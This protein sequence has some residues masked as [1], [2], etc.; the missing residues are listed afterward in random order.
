[1]NPEVVL[2]TAY[3]A[4]LTSGAFALEWLS[5]H[6]HRR[7][8][9]YRTAGFTYDPAHDH[10]RCP[11]GGHLW[12]YE[13]DRQLR[14]VRVTEAERTSATPARASRSAPIPTRDPRWSLTGLGGRRKLSPREGTGVRS[15]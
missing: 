13:L 10:W 8:L 2:T 5:A 14:L 3:A 7:T 9:R 12:P 6:T 15:P 1:M 11:E 4:F